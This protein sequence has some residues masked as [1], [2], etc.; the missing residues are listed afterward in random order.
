M[1]ILSEPDKSHR[2]RLPFWYT[3]SVEE[4]MVAQ[5]LCIEPCALSI[6]LDDMACRPMPGAIAAAAVSAAMGAALICKAARLAL[7]HGLQGSEKAEMEMV[8]ERAHEQVSALIA[9]ADADTRAYRSVLDTRG[10]V[11]Q[12]P[13]RQRAWQAAVDVPL[14]LAEACAPLEDLVSSVLDRCPRVARADLQ[15]GGWL[16]HTASRAGRLAVDENIDNCGSCD[17]AGLLRLR[18]AALRERE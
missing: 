2:H 12:E 17:E 11:Q 16:L 6:N 8:A 3:V 14:C 15:V 1:S 7:Q 18:L 13:A 4:M 10:M 9:L 5:E